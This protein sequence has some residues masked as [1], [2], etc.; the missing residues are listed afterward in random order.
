MDKFKSRKLTALAV[1]I[2]AI[3]LSLGIIDESQLRDMSLVI[4]MSITTI[5]SVYI[6]VQGII[7]QIEAKKK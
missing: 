2:G 7:D 6:T 3:L 5:A 4:S 1:S